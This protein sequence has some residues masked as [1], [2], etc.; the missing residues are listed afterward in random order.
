MSVKGTALS[1]IEE[2]LTRS[3]EEDFQ[4]SREQT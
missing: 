3:S 1:G 2:V 4:S